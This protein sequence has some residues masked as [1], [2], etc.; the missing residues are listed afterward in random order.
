MV[1]TLNYGI[2][3]VGRS[4]SLDFETNHSYALSVIK[5]G[6]VWDSEDQLPLRSTSS[7]RTM[8]LDCIKKPK[9]NRINILFI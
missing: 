6:G 8:L 7:A 4:I 3:L 5:G 2:Y 9:I 1:I